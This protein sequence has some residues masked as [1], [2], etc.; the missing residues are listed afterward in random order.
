MRIRE[1]LKQK[2]KKQADLAAFRGCSTSA[3]TFYATG[4]REPDIETLCKIADFFGV[5]VDYLLGRDNSSIPSVE[6]SQP[7]IFVGD[8]EVKDGALRVYVDD[9]VVEVRVLVR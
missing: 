7:R 5:S 6:R 1:L 9:R 4:R 3:I 8:R 2:K